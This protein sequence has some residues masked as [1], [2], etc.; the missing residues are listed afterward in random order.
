MEEQELLIRLL[1]ENARLRASLKT[2]RRY[3]SE[4]QEFFQNMQSEIDSL[5]LDRVISV[6]MSIETDTQYIQ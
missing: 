3:C 2:A 5:I 4:C 1:T 6:H